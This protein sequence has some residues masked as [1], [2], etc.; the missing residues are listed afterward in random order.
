[1]HNLKPSTQ[2]S[3]HSQYTLD[4]YAESLFMRTATAPQYLVVKMDGCQDVKLSSR[5]TLNSW[6]KMSWHILPQKEDI[7]ML[8]LPVVYILS[9]QNTVFYRYSS[10]QR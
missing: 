2:N 1:M 3:S 10:V 4:H 9:V 6:E 5:C 7:S 8:A